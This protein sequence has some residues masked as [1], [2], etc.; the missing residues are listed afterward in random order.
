[1]LHARGRAAGAALARGDGG[2]DGARDA[3]AKY[4]T[5]KVLRA[6]AHLEGARVRNAARDSAVA[7]ALDPQSREAAPRAERR[8]REA[9]GA[10]GEQEAR[11]GGDQVGRHG[12]RGRGRRG[13]GTMSA[14]EGG[15]NE[16]DCPQSGVTKHEVPIYL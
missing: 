15:A 14:I 10:Q 3:R 9:H 7:S 12:G 11:E 2:A 5:A 4:V 6:K 16:T 8:A 13:L 1:M